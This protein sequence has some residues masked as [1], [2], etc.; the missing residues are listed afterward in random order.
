MR[1]LVTGVNG[2]AG[3]HLFRH[4][5]ASGDEVVGLIKPDTGALVFDGEEVGSNRGISVRKMQRSVQMVFQDSYASLNPR[6]TLQDTIAFGPR[7]AG[8]SRG[9]ARRRADAVLNLVGL[10]PERYAARYPHEL[11]EYEICITASPTVYSSYAACRLSY[12]SPRRL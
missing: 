11:F 10:D 2:F 4:L 7:I 9:D 5:V 6:L 3:R 12:Q 1:A 8:R